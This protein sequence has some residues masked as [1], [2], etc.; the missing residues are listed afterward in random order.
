MRVC[1]IFVVISIVRLCC[2][3]CLLYYCLFCL[4]QALPS[5]ARYE[6]GRRRTAADG[7]RSNKSLRALP[8]RTRYDNMLFLIVLSV[9]CRFC[10]CVFVC[11]VVYV[12]LFIISLIYV[13]INMLCS[14]VAS[15]T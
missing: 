12:L 1:C 14:F 7:G 15:S 6:N 13:R 10:F 9:V 4:L 3:F 11:I 5:R 2:Y 8:S